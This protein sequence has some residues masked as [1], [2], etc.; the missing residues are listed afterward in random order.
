[1]QVLLTPVG[2]SVASD[3]A[4]TSAAIAVWNPAI[5]TPSTRSTEYVRGGACNPPADTTPPTDTLATDGCDPLVPDACG[6][7]FPS[8]VWLVDDPKTPTG[9]HVQ[10]GP[11]TLPEHAHQPTDPAPWTA[12]DGFSAGM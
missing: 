12:S 11:K 8:N 9:K 4:P 3:T 1:M 5:P 6:F 7:P 10:F 2:A